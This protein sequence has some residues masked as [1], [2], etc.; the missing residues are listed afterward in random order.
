MWFLVT[1]LEFIKMFKAHGK[2]KNVLQKRILESTNLLH[3]NLFFL[4]CNLFR[5]L[6]WKIGYFTFLKNVE[7][8]AYVLA[9]VDVWESYF[10]YEGFLFI[11]SFWMFS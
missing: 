3:S 9:N 5:R 11:T 1:V 4:K 2:K 10:D 6:C 8:Q 7:L